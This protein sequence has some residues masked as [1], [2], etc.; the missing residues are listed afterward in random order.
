MSS[1]DDE[2]DGMLDALGLAQPAKTR[3]P[4]RSVI[5][6]ETPRQERNS[7][8]EVVSDASPIPKR[9]R[10][11]NPGDV[12]ELSDS[13]DDRRT[14]TVDTTMIRSEQPINPADV[15]VISINSLSDN[16]SEDPQLTSRAASTCVTEPQTNTAADQ[17]VIS[18]Q[19]LSDSEGAPMNALDEENGSINH[20]D[21]DDDPLYQ[22]ILV[23]D[24]LQSQS[25]Q[26][27][28]PD[29]IPT[30]SAPATTQVLSKR[31]TRKRKQELHV[32]LESSWLESEVV[33]K[34]RAL[35]AAHTPSPFQMRPPFDCTIQGVVS[36]EAIDESHPSFIRVPMACR[37]FTAIEFLEAIELQ[38][39]PIYDVLA[40]L[41]DFLRDSTARIF[42][43]VEGMDKALI[44]QQ[45]KNKATSLTFAHV[46]NACVHLFMN[47]FCHIKFTTDI[48]DTA[49]YL[50]SL[51][52]EV[53]LLPQ[54]ESV[55]LLTH[56][57]RLTSLR[58]TALGDTSNELTNTWLRM[59]QMIPGMSEERAQ[60][61]I[62]F[63]P[64]MHSL[65]DVYHNPALP[66]SAKEVL[67]AEKL[68]P[69][70]I[71]V[72]LSRRIYTVFTS[73]DPNQVV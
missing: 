55:D 22:P 25:S 10:A 28:I 67:L 3:K 31:K 4:V 46:Q 59:L 72:V 19:S 13:D 61:V 34:F 40:G 70:S 11:N 60:R 47:S 41:R 26:T 23:Y 58:A 30:P 17:S 42:L 15:S 71:E 38:Y 53:A 65:L 44:T 5:S 2:I 27:S 56:V 51:T 21:F 36:W 66:V 57:G 43:V 37:F 8:P 18:I 14:R 35:L 29:A 50:Y 54:A 45:R 33:V 32:S 24:P 68:N 9:S 63:Y 69:N 20:F 1:S 62:G 39:K 64:T 49:N 6:S 12:I 73:T 48:E 7:L 16:E 52:K